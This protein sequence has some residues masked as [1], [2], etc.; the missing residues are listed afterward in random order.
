MEEHDVIDQPFDREDLPPD[1]QINRYSFRFTEDNELIIREEETTNSF[2]LLGGVLFGGMGLFF[3]YL[4][5]QGWLKEGFHYFDIIYIFFSVFMLGLGGVSIYSG[6]FSK[7]TFLFTKEDLTLEKRIGSGKHYNK[8]KF[9]SVFIKKI[10]T[11]NQYG[12][13]TNYA[14][15]ICLRNNVIRRDDA[16]LFLFNVEGRSSIQSTFGYLDTKGMT[17][18]EQDSLR[19]G[20]IISDY[21]EIPFKS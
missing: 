8:S 15:Q 21:W 3:A 18:A 4:L 6:Y 19:I 5:Y 10:I 11:S 1:F 7:Q 13:E 2:A 20:Q 17:I 16:E 14:M 9:A 12:S